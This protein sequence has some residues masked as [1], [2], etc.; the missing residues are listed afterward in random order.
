MLF[1]VLSSHPNPRKSWNSPN[2]GLIDILISNPI[3]SR[4]QWWLCSHKG[5]SVALTAVGI[6]VFSPTCLAIPAFQVP[7]Q[8]PQLFY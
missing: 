6:S 2:P 4:R 3:V 8:K 7:E 1:A 5:A